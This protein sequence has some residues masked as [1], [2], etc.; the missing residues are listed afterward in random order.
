MKSLSVICLVMGVMF[1]LVQTIQGQIPVSNECLFYTNKASTFRT[2][3]F[4]VRFMGDKVWVKDVMYNE[5]RD[6]LAKSP[7][8]YDEQRWVDRGTES[9]S[10]WNHNGLHYFVPPCERMFVFCPNLSTPSRLVYTRHVEYS[11]THPF[12][13][14]AMVDPGFGCVKTELLGNMGVYG[15]KFTYNYDM[16]IAFSL[17]KSNFIFWR[18]QSHNLDG[19]I[20][21][22]TKLLL[23][24]HLRW[25]V[26]ILQV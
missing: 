6:N 3:D 4:C 18:E 11:W 24:T 10:T 23:K 17:D 1:G 7:S 12:E 21:N 8:Y 9:H 14:S 16:Y 5:V 19:E 15:K 25:C 20:N 13:G 2:L 26:F 22:K